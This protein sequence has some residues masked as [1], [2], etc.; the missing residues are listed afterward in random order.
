[1]LGK[2]AVKI[3]AAPVMDDDDIA[4]CQRLA[5]MGL[6]RDFSAFHGHR[7]RLR[8]RIWGITD[9]GRAVLE[10]NSFTDARKPARLNLPETVKEKKDETA[11]A[12]TRP[13]D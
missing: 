9:A 1:M 13:L 7:I 6:A 3:Q 12:K 2:L 8:L 11:S 4:R 5:T 10:Q